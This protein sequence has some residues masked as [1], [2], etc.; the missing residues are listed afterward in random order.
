MNRGR[1]KNNKSGYKGVHW[2]TRDK[3]WVSRINLTIDGIPKVFSLGNYLT[4][5]AAA[6]AY[7]KKAKELFGEFA[8]LNKL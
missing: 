7:N 8:Y 2:S 4:K 5:E 1:N 3:R 6:E